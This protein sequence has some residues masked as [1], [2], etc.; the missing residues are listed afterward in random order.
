MEL[1]ILQLNSVFKMIDMISY[2][3]ISGTSPI[4]AG[5]GISLL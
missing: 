5:G 2:L 4:D 3:T 1:H